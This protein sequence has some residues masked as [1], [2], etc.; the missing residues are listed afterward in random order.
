MTLKA[1][2]RQIP[3]TAYL[4]AALSV[5]AVGAYAAWSAHQRQIGAERVLTAQAVSQRDSLAVVLKGKTATFRRDTVRVFRSIETVDTLIQHRVDTALVHQTDTVKI[6]IREATAIQDTLK[7]CRS[8]VRD[9]ASIQADLRG[10]IRADSQIIRGL[11]Q[12][13]P[14]RLTPWKDRA[15][16]AAT[17]YALDRLA[18]ALQKR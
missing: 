4:Y 7:A 6:T 18:A 15:I 16:G 14:S 5:G 9:C 17:M 13:V 12:Q 3:S 1:L 11:R 8:L 10:F 2:L